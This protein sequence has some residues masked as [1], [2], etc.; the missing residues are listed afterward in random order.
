MDIDLLTTYNDFIKTR[1]NEDF[2]VLI[3]L[4]KQTSY[5]DV[6]SILCDIEK[7][8]DLLNQQNIDIC[9]IHNELKTIIETF[10]KVI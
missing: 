4:A 9:F 7:R 10:E 1:S 2:N 5:N 3:E 8:F 6:N